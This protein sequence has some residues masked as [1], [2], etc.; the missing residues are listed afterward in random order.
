MKKGKGW[1]LRGY[2]NPCYEYEDI[3]W[4]CIDGRNICSVCK[5]KSNDHTYVNWDLIAQDTDW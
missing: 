1:Y 3:A 2:D 5:R 4:L